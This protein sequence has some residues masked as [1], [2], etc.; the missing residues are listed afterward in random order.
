MNDYEARISGAIALIET[1][2][3]KLLQENQVLESK[4]EHLTQENTKL[5]NKTESVIDKID[6]YMKELEEIRRNYGDSNCSN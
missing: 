5:Q 6:D 1:R 3:E 4:I 2:V